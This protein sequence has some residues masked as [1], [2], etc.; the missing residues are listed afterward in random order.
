MEKKTINFDEKLLNVSKNIRKN[1]KKIQKSHIN[2]IKPQSVKELLLEKL[3]NYKKEKQR[4]KLKEK[5]ESFIPKNN[6]ISDNFIETI[7]RRK[8]KTEQ[9]IHMDDIPFYNIQEE[10]KKNNITIENN[11]NL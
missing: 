3:K 1:K 8:N 2:K 7:Q 5:N 10:N 4:E 6:T 11:T 9:N